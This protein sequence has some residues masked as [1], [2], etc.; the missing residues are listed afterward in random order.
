MASVSASMSG[1]V[2][3]YIQKHSSPN[4]SS[5]QQGSSN[6]SA[7]YL[8]LATHIKVVALKITFRENVYKTVH[9]RI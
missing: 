1:N 7:Y 3:T 4:N 9:E 6:Y 8:Q 2:F 5:C